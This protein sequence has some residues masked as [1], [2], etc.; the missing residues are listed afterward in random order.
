MQV[1]EDRQ[2]LSAI[3]FKYTRFELFQGWN[4]KKSRLDRKGC[5]FHNMFLEDSIMKRCQ[6]CQKELHLDDV[7]ADEATCP[8]CRTDLHVCFH[9]RQYSPA[10]IQECLVKGIALVKDKKRKNTCD[11]FE[12]R[13]FHRQVKVSDAYR[14]KQKID[15]LF[16]G[17]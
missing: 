8:H 5:F 14:A 12:F 6:N 11:S 10:A 17:L 13:E 15:D 9:C 4:S 16:G 1:G 3:I 2:Q 7:V